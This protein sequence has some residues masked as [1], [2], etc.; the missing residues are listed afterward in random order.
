MRMGRSRLMGTAAVAALSL[1][2]L[3]P[4]TVSA[5]G[6]LS[7]TSNSTFKLRT[8]Q[9]RVV[10]GID[11]TLVNRK[12]PTYS[13]GACPGA[14]GSRCRIQTNYYYDSWGLLFVPAGA[15]RL[16]VRSPGVRSSVVERQR[17]WTSY[18]ITFPDLHYGQTRK[19][20]VVYELP[21]AKP[22]SKHRTRVT[23][24]YTYFCWHGEPGD[25]GRVT[26]IL[27]PGYDAT[28]FGEKTRVRK[29]RKATTI[30]PVFRGNPSRVYA[31]TDA[32]KP[33]KLIRSEVAGP[34]GQMVVVEGWPEDSEWSEQTT[35][36]V[37]EAL[38]R[39][40]ELIGRPMPLDELVIR[41]VSRQSLY[42]YGSSFSR[43]R[44]LVRLGEHI[45]NP[46]S[47]PIAV[48]SAWFNQRNIATTWLHHGLADWAGLEVS[49]AGCW[50][51]GDY[52]GKGRPNLAR[53][54][55]LDDRPTDQ[56][57]AIVDWQFG[58]ACNLVED[59]AERIGEERMQG[60]L[61]SLLDGTPK[62]GP[63]P[64]ERRG[65]LKAATWKD[66]LDAVDELGL[67]P[68]GETDLAWGQ[69]ALLD[70]G[71]ARPKQLRGRLAAREAYH[72]SLSAMDG[73]SMPRVVNDLMGRW[74]FERAKPA[75][76]LAAD[77]FA[78]IAGNESMSDADRAAF[79]DRFED[80]ASLKGL[81]ALRKEAAAFV[82]TEP[83]PLSVVPTEAG[84][85]QSV[86]SRSAGS[87][88]AGDGH[89]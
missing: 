55:E 39:L 83:D 19:I 5:A 48:A 2:L 51:A 18:K 47:G 10:V 1:A 60:V 65:K 12:A 74:A 75:I 81:R 14:P 22:R 87:P 80:A 70:V 4:T 37:E 8:G 27:P 16:E 52:P 84:V 41:E 23:D 57:E 62:Y 29:T 9:D 43:G 20:R 68:A 88:V 44:A 63:Q 32:F 54:R 3:V 38:P 76:E 6:G 25:R 13:I 15:T 42:G 34:G 79:L 58:S 85:D 71:A 64:A 26:V 77:A 21:G 28:T 40:E 67:V 72:Q 49:V 31:C 61:A 24:A 11:V 33:S 59:V 36:V 17:Y 46:S 45:D 35:E 82:S 53:W 78:A 50:P 69:Q 73:T 56:Q 89:A 7:I 30:T 86:R 66:W